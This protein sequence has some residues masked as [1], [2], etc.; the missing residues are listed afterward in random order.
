MLALQPSAFLHLRPPAT[1]SHFGYS[2]PSLI[3]SQWSHPRQSSLR[4]LVTRRQGGSQ[5]PRPSV[6][7]R[8]L[9]QAPLSPLPQSAKV[10]NPR[11]RQR[12]VALD[13]RASPGLR[14]GRSSLRTRR[15]SPG[16][17]LHRG[18]P[19][20]LGTAEPEAEALVHLE[21][22]ANV[23]P[24]STVHQEIQ[25]APGLPRQIPK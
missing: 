5:A 19:A 11:L 17:S 2:L 9:E 6:R 14:S 18:K 20:G 4:P 13:C 25:G 24:H 10:R 21:A 1:N 22:P 8:P 12:P 23:K 3:P 15:R 16:R 7:L